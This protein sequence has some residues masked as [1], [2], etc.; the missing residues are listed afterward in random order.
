M[1]EEKMTVWTRKELPIR[2]SPVNFAAFAG[3]GTITSNAWGVRVMKTG[4]AYIYCRD[5]RYQDRITQSILTGLDSSTLKDHV[6]EV[7]HMTATGW[8]TKNSAFMV[9]FPVVFQ[10]NDRG[11]GNRCGR[12]K[13]T[14]SPCEGPAG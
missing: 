4:D 10:Q 5:N 12:T 11:S 8:Q 9:N 2:E 6:G 3:D 7:L 13:P 1:T 14:R